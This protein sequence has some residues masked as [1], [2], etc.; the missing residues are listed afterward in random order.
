MSMPQLNLSSWISSYHNTYHKGW[1]SPRRMWTRHSLQVVLEAI[2]LSNNHLIVGRESIMYRRARSLNDTVS[3]LHPIG[4]AS[5]SPGTSSK[6]FVFFGHSAPRLE[7]SEHL[8]FYTCLWTTSRTRRGWSE[9]FGTWFSST[10]TVDGT[11]LPLVVCCS[12]SRVYSH[13]LFLQT[14]VNNI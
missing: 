7:F 8:T 14:P 2:N 9:N 6:D 10:S 5:T 12:S 11:M 3:N 1:S 13:L 4:L